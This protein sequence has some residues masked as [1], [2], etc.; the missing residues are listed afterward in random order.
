[1]DVHPP[2]HGAIGCPVGKPEGNYG[3]LWLPEDNESRKP[4]SH[5]TKTIEGLAVCACST[6]RIKTCQGSMHMGV[7]FFREPLFECYFAFIV[8]KR[9]NTF[10]GGPSLRYTQLSFQPWLVTGLPVGPSSFL[11]AWLK[12]AGPSSQGINPLL[13]PLR[14]M[15]EMPVCPRFQRKPSGSTWFARGYSLAH[16]EKDIVCVN[17]KLFWWLNLSPAT[18]LCS[19]GAV[20]TGELRQKTTLQQTRTPR[21]RRLACIQPSWKEMSKCSDCA[22]SAPFQLAARFRIPR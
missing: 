20:K 19:T 5:V 13:A 12:K 21:P 16:G 11:S 17:S 6:S 15:P 8:E 9:E 2:K 14:D 22:A 3:H 10:F 18:Y 1:M 7:F 4:P